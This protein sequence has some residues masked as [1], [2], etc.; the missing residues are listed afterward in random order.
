MLSFWSLSLFYKYTPWTKYKQIK[1][2]KS[3][4]VSGCCCCSIKLFWQR[5]WPR[6]D[7]DL[8]MLLWIDNAQNTGNNRLISIITFHTGWK[9]FHTPS[10]W[11][12]EKNCK[13]KSMISLQQKCSTWRAGNWTPKLK[14]TS[15][16]MGQIILCFILGMQTKTVVINQKIFM[17]FGHCDTK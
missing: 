10:S 15:K 6:L 2:F 16:S 17:W 8:L 12:G 9:A 3:T 11:Y 13:T 7:W 5:K 4:D 14:W 1:E